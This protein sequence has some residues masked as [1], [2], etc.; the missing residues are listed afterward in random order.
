MKSDKWTTKDINVVRNNLNHT[1]EY[2]NNL[3][4]KVRSRNAIR[5]VKWKIRKGVI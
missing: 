2:I 5:T 3:L 4:S 1:C